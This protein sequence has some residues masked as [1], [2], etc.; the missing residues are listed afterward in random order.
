MIRWGICFSFGLLVLAALAACAGQPAEVQSTSEVVAD[1]VP[2]L[3]PTTTPATTSTPQPVATVAPTATPEPTETPEPTA[4]PTSTPEPTATMPATVGMQNAE[5]QWWDGNE[6]QN[7]QQAGPYQFNGSSLEVL[8]ADTKLSIQVPEEMIRLIQEGKLS[9][10]TFENIVTN[11][12]S[13]MR[14]YDADGNEWRVFY[15]EN[16]EWDNVVYA[17]ALKFDYEEEKLVK[18][19][20]QP[21]TGPM[22]I[23]TE[24]RGADQNSWGLDFGATRLYINSFQIDTLTPG[25]VTGELNGEAFDIPSLLITIRFL[26]PETRELVTTTFRNVDWVHTPWLYTSDEVETIAREIVGMRQTLI[27]H[28]NGLSRDEML[29]VRNRSVGNEQ[30]YM[31]EILKRFPQLWWAIFTQED[32]FNSTEETIEALLLGGMYP[33]GYINFRSVQLQ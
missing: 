10:S 31:S 3:P 2:T 27:T 8:Q 11:D 28:P 26:H 33:Y 29:Y 6:W 5:G 1:I 9:L 32:K 21:L 23:S 4:E 17:G 16:P 18:V 24:V 7:L 25:T 20:Q 15:Y 19:E 14:G 12:S 30:E 22:Q 13:V